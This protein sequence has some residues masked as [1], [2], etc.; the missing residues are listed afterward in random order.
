MVIQVV[1]GDIG[2]R[3]HLRAP[4]HGDE[5]KTGQFHYG[6][7]VLLY[8][9]NDGKQRN[10]YVSAE[11][12]PITLC[13]KQSRRECRR[14]GF[15]VAAG[16]PDDPAGT[17]LKKALDL[18]CDLYTVSD[19]ILDLRLRP[20]DPGC[21]ED[22]IRLLQVIQIFLTENEMNA[23][24]DALFPE[25][26]QFIQGLPVAEGDVRPFTGELLDERFMA[27]PG[28]QEEDLL[29]RQGRIE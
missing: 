24:L 6:N 3:A 11:M 10:S 14:G 22:K 2:D 16:D 9:I 7:V 1:G 27:D 18:G 20:V 28:S 15:A 23:P 13:L 17:V 12:Y 25:F 5:L 8:L 29:P 26:S 19:G 4:P 21:A